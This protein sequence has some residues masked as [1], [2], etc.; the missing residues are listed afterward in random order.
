[1]YLPPFF[2]PFNRARE[3]APGIIYKPVLFPKPCICRRKCQSLG[4]RALRKKEQ[5]SRGY[6]ES[7]LCSILFIY[8]SLY[9]PLTCYRDFFCHDESS[10][11]RRQVS[12]IK[13]KK[14][15]GLISDLRVSSWISPFSFPHFE[16]IPPYDLHLY[17][18]DSSLPLPYQQF[19]AADT[20]HTFI[21]L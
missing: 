16:S 12:S 17:L 18:P 6:R 8:L 5:A 4:S 14:V 7:H 2:L 20:F 3:R 13:K 19:F 11:S 10:I 21:N 1:M 15:R 9:C